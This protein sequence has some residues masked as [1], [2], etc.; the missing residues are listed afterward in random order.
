[1]KKLTKIIKQWKDEAGLSSNDIVLISACPTVHEE[2]KICTS[3][4]GYMIG[5]G[6]CLFEKYNN[7]IRENFKNIKKISFV[8]TESWYIR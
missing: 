7:L 6:G 1:M 3:K 4:P 8:E 5:K 2:L